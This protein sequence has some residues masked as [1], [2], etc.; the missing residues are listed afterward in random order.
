MGNWKEEGRVCN[1]LLHVIRK[2]PMSNQKRQ[3]DSN[4]EPKKSK[5]VMGFEPGQLVLNAVA[6]PL[7]PPPLSD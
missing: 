4:S 7:A 1:V 3:I 2:R 5:S 6:L